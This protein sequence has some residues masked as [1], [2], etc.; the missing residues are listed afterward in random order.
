MI[1]N[2][3]DDGCEVVDEK[4]RKKMFTK[5]KKITSEK[6][7]ILAIFGII[8]LAI[9]VNLVELACSAGLELLF[10]NTWGNGFGIIG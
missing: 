2:K 9:S 6:K 8:A 1:R 10:I 5:I 4:K 7:F 3:K